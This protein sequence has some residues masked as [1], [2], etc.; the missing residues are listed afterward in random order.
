MIQDIK[1]SLYYLFINVRYP[2]IVFW[3]ILLSIFVLSLL[4]STI[5]E[6]DHV[7]FQASFT[8]YIFCLVLGMLTVKNTIPYLLKMS[9]TRKIIYV[10]IGVYFL[11]IALV[12]ALLA[13]GLTKIIDLLGKTVVSGDFII[14][15]GEQEFNF[16]FTHLSQ[17]LQNDTFV[18]QVT[19]DAIIAFAALCMMFFIGLIFYRFGLIG[20][21]TFLGAMFLLYIVS[22]AQG[23]FI[24]LVKYIFDHYSLTLYYQLLGISIVIYLLSFAMIRRLT[25]TSA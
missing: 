9:V 16:R 20:G 6:G 23:S 7:L 5:G 19:I 8:I 14:A 21:F 1:G 10:S 22:I 3:S 18:T 2:F 11:M 25:I 4:F 13:N 24:D 15:N 12:Q 17:F